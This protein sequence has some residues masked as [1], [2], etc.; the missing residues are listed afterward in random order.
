MTVNLIKLQYLLIG[1]S[2]DKVWTS[3]GDSKSKREM[4]NLCFSEYVYSVDQYL[5]GNFLIYFPTKLS[6]LEKSQFLCLDSNV[7]DGR[8]IWHMFQCSARYVISQVNPLFRELIVGESLLDLCLEIREKLWNKK[9]YV[10]RSRRKSQA[11]MPLPPFD[12]E[13]EPN[14]WFLFLY[15]GVNGIVANCYS[16]VLS[17]LNCEVVSKLWR[18]M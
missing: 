10:L 9:H 12:G 18:D 6:C 14:E 4:E 5:S 8:R 1:I 15:C 17:D 13:W 16:E 7:L 11:L 3:F 2:G